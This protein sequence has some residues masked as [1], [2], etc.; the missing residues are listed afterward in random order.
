MGTLRIQTIHIQRQGVILHRK[1]SFL[2]DLFLAF[3]DDRI[4]K[5]FHPTALQTDQMVVM[6]PL[7][8]FINGLG[9]LE[10]APGQQTGMLKLGQYPIN[11]GQTNLFTFGK[12]SLVNLFGT[13]MLARIRNK[14]T[15]HLHPWSRRF[16]TYI[17]EILV[18]I[19]HTLLLSL[20]FD[21]ECGQF[22]INSR[23]LQA[24]NLSSRQSL[25]L[26]CD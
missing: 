12:Q 20:S 2:G 10:M 8:E 26:Q 4:M 15:Q 13:H 11:G 21:I 18:H 24:N 6:F 14:Q 5:L 17:F 3:F 16:E 1:A 7:I 19:H 9:G 23:P 22:P 25:E